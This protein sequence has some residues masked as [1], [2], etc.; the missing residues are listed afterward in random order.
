ME[1][2]WV[3]VPVYVFGSCRAKLFLAFVQKVKERRCAVLLCMCVIEFFVLS[4]YDN[5][6]Q[7]CK[8]TIWEHSGECNGVQ[9][10]MFVR[11]GCEI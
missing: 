11:N 6:E 1:E 2:L 4:C 3:V 8:G 5:Q 9:R 10:M 7:L